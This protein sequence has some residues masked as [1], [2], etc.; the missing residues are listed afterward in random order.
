MTTSPIP[1]SR[2]GW[3][4]A[5][6][7]LALAAPWIAPALAQQAPPPVVAI[8]A[9][10]IGG[11]VLGPRGPEAGVWV[12]AETRDLPTR[13]IRIVAT[14]DE[15]RFV[16]PDLPLATY[17][18]FVRGYG[19]VDSQRVRARPGQILELAATPAPDAARTYP[20]I[21]WYAM[22]RIP[23]AARFG[24]GG[25]IPAGITR[26]EWLNLMKSNGCVGCHQMGQASTRAIPKAFLDEFP[27]HEDAW[28][29][30]V[31]SG[32]SGEQMVS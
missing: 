26:Q 14:D 3:I 29:R 18:V 2:T 11:R 28:M 21:H 1:S 4:A 5:A 8:D 24:G 20:A 6:L 17:E 22:L 10:D 12:V 32:Q 15:G 9:D 7:W 13:F 30:R 19:L 23:E 27:S 16:V 31:Q 25:D